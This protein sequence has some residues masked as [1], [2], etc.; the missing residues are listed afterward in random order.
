MI[1]KLPRTDI[2]L[3]KLSAYRDSRKD[4]NEKI[5]ATTARPDSARDESERQKTQSFFKVT[6]VIYYR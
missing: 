6:L 1:V 5:I 3:T 2:Q 4:V